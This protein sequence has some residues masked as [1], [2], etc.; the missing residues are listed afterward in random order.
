MY[1]REDLL[2]QLG[3]LQEVSNAS[4]MRLQRFYKMMGEKNPGKLQTDFRSSL[5]SPVSECLS[6]DSSVS[7][8]VH[9]GTVHLEGLRYKQVKTEPALVFSVPDSIKKEGAGAV[10]DG[11]G[12]GKGDH[13]LS[14]K[15]IKDP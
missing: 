8:D 9:L 14:H 12:I 11:R 6:G 4:Y 7:T 2:V 1:P 10:Q 3:C 5:C 13:F 15:F